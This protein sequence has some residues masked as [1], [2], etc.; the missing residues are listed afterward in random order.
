VNFLATEYFSLRAEGYY[1]PTRA[2]AVLVVLSI[3]LLTAS[4]APLSIHPCLLVALRVSLTF[5][6]LEGK[7][8]QQILCPQAS[9]ATVT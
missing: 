3:V 7:R 1:S 4:I 2:T 6:G 9:E 5:G 8:N